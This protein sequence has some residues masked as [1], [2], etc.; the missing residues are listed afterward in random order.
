MKKLIECVPNFSEGRNYEKI[1]EIVDAMRNVGKITILDVDSGSDTNRT[2]VTMVGSPNSIMEAAFTGIK[3]ASEILDMTNHKGSHPRI[4][5]TDVCPFIPISGVTDEECIDLSRKVGKRVGEELNIP[6]YLYEKSATDSMRRKLPNIRKGEYEGLTKKL[7]DPDWNPDFGPTKVHIKAGAIVI[8]CRDFLIAYNINL[9]TRDT[10]LATDIAFELREVGRSKRLPNPNSKNLLDGEI[11]RDKEGKPVKVPGMFKQV[12]GIGWYVAD[13]DRAQISIN[14]NNYKKS[15]IHDVF[16]QACKLATK[17]GIR[18][19]G[20][21]LIGL[22]PLDAM[23]MAGEHYLKKQNRSLGVPKADVIECAV[24]SLG[25]NDVTKFDPY[26]KIIDYAVI[27]NG[28]RSNLFDSKFIEELSKNSPAPGGGSVAALGGALGAALSSMVAALTHE[29]KEMLDSKPLMDEI[30]VEA[31]K[32]KDRLTLLIDE[33]TKAFNNMI[34]ASRLSENTIE[35]KTT[36]NKAIMNANIYAIE[37]PL[38]TAK[39]CYSVMTLA[40]KLV[41]NGNPNSVSD[42]GVAAEISLA[43]L[44]GACM[45]VLINLKGLNDDSYCELIKNEINELVRDGEMLHKKIYKNTLS[46]I[47]RKK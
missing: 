36:K 28:K 22:I 33:D 2:V 37:I 31:Q 7:S 10:R 13:Y 34:E 41:E 12:K 27:Q 44:R 17:R 15:K 16:D 43:G 21:E 11:V 42:A 9:N 32:L 18:V 6:V 35:E 25:L 30:G 5:A 39:K 20:S 40:S 4:G 29:K 19:T 14:F 38:E 3:T 45:N 47:G 23:I 1:N 26:E 46:V 24:Q 8:G